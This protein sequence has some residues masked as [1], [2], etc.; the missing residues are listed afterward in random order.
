MNRCIFPEENYLFPLLKKEA[1]ASFTLLDY[2]NRRSKSSPT[3]N[4]LKGS[5]GMT[6]LYAN[7]ENMKWVSIQIAY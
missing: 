3:K 4:V 5:H 1:E 2:L 7:T 6:S